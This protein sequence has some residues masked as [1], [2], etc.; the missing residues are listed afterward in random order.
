VQVRLVTLLLYLANMTNE[1]KVTV[2][3]SDSLHHRI[4]F[5]RPPGAPWEHNPFN[6]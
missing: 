6:Q 5:P 2:L 1:I 4:N 3:L